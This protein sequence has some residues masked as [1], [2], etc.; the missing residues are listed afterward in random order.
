MDLNRHTIT[1]RGSDDVRISKTCQ[2]H[3]LNDA[4]CTNV[5]ISGDI[6]EGA[7]S[8]AL[9]SSESSYGV[10]SIVDESVKQYFRS[11][12]DDSGLLPGVVLQNIYNVTW[13][14]LHGTKFC[15]DGSACCNVLH[16]HKGRLNELYVP[17]KYD[18]DDLV[19]QRFKGTNPLTF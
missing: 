6:S 19:E 4:S 3:W 1:L 12:L 13:V 9:F 11:N 18:I 8:H 2:S 17:V 14:T 5:V 7:T 10:L 16:V 15:K